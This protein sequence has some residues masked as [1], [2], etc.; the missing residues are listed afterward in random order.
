[1]PPGKAILNADVTAKPT[2]QSTGQD[3]WLYGRRDARA[4]THALNQA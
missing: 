2:R 1:L 3:A 4:T